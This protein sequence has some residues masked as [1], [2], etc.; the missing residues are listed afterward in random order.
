MTNFEFFN[1]ALSIKLRKPYYVYAILFGLTSLIIP[2]GA[3][4]LVNNLALSGIWVNVFSFMIVFAIGLILSNALGYFLVIIKEYIQRE[5]FIFETITWLNHF[6]ERG[7]KYFLESINLLKTF[8]NVFTNFVEMGLILIFGLITIILFHPVFLFLPIFFI[9]TFYLISRNT[10][11]AMKTSLEESDAKYEMFNLI[12]SNQNITENCF[13]NY[14]SQRNKH[15][16]FIKSI[17]LKISILNIS[18]HVTL[19]GIGI[20][21]IESD[22][23]SIGQLIAA[24]I[25]LSGILQS[26]AKLPTTLESLYDFETSVFKLKKALKVSHND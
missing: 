7:S 14:L 23:F 9:F 26:I 15:F 10:R 22:Q 20:Y 18:C 17:S 4:F 1:I 12:L 2:L 21:L 5:L 13:E 6:E 19:L 11:L 24:E 25:I 16:S 3:Q 8:A